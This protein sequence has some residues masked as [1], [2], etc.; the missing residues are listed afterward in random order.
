MQSEVDNEKDNADWEKQREE[1]KRKDDEKT[2]KN[3]KRREKK[4]NARGKKGG[5]KDTMME[6]DKPSTM[7]GPSVSSQVEQDASAEGQVSY[8]EVPGVI[9]H[10]ED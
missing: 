6:V 8:G 2:E 3:R 9:I 7:K 5:G 4:R 1:A 10:D